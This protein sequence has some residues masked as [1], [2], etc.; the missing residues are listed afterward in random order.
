[1]EDGFFERA[2]T[3]AGISVTVPHLEERNK[4]HLIHSD[5]MENRV[6]EEAK[7]FFESIIKKY[8]HCEAVILGCTELPMVVTTKTSPL[9]I[10]DPVHL[11]CTAAVAYS[12]AG[13]RTL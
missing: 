1:M 4:V 5:L 8:D 6:T 2:L 7:S 10:I 11:Q 9:P 3:Q 13:K 12:L